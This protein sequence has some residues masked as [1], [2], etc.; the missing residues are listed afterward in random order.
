[1]VELGV[2]R[3]TPHRGRGR[4]YTL[5]GTTHPDWGSL[6]VSLSSQEWPKQGLELQSGER[7]AGMYAHDS[8]SRVTSIEWITIHVLSEV[9]VMTYS[10]QAAYLPAF[11]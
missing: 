6:I 10:F 8:R 2:Q 1:M 5:R 7:H 9:R 3:K 4:G 11:M